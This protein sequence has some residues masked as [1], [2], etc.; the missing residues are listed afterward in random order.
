M[1][2]VVG[3]LTRVVSRGKGERKGVVGCKKEEGG[4]EGGREGMS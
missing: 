1:G 2:G 3:K 4:R